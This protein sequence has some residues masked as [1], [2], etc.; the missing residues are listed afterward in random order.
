MHSPVI[1]NSPVNF[2]FQVINVS[3]HLPQPEMI[4]TTTAIISES[5]QNLTLSHDLKESLL[6]VQIHQRLHV[7]LDIVLFVWQQKEMVLDV[8]EKITD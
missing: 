7:S 1:P 2:D 8:Q 5:C 3:E 4:G 6:I